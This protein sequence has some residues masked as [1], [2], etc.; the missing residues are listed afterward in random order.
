MNNF[1][2]KWIIGDLTPKRFLISVVA[3][4]ILI[5]LG[6]I[7]WAA[8]FSS[9]M[10]FKPGPPSYSLEEYHFSYIVSET[11]DTIAI[12]HRETPKTD[13][14][15]LL[16]HGNAEDIGDIS[17]ICSSF[18]SAGFNCII[19]DYPGY[20]HTNGIPTEKSCY[21]TL[22]A[23][24]SYLTVE[25]KIPPKSIILLGRSMG[26]GPSVELARKKEV[27]GLILESAFTSSFRVLTG[28]KILPF[29]RFDNIAKLPKINVPLL[30]IHGRHDEVIPFSHGEK[31]FAKANDPKFNLWIDNASHN[32]VMIKGDALYWEEIVQFSTFVRMIHEKK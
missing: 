6:I 13:M 25:K 12:Q 11:G 27:G 4:P 21:N 1:V 15:I 8:F 17:F 16:S 3:V 23:V 2:K 7:I 32:D 14:T 19:Y 18:R 20:G 28:I 9:G 31:L 26:S 29:D 24:Y 10:L 22:E 30:V 5:Y